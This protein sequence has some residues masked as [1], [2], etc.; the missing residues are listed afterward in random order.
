ME[1]GKEL[2]I[3]TIRN[4]E[5]TPYVT[6]LEL[7]LNEMVKGGFEHFMLKEIY[8][9]PRSIKDSMRGRI[10]AAKGIVSLGGIIDYEQKF[11]AAN[12]IIIIACGTSWHAGLVGEYLFEDLARTLLRLNMHQSLGIE[13]L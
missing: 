8:E 1:R 2:K 13:T 6:K 9:Q 11:V 4:K 3:T 7:N 5:K 10:N 12:R